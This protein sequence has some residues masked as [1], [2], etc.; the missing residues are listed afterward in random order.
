MEKQQQKTE[1]GEVEWDIS[2]EA[3]KS[4]VVAA[5]HNLLDRLESA[6]PKGNGRF[7][8]NSIPPH[9]LFT[10]WG[11]PKNT[12]L[13][14]TLRWC[15][16]EA[17]TMQILHE[18]PAFPDKKWHIVDRQ[19]YDGYQGRGVF[20]ALLAACEHIVQEFADR[21]K[22]EQ[23]IEVG[24][25]QPKVFSAFEHMGYVV[26][27][28]KESEENAEI[29]RDPESYNT[30]VVQHAFVHVQGSEK[31]RKMAERTSDDPYCFHRATLIEKPSPTQEDAVRVTLAKTFVPS[32]A[33]IERAVEETGNSARSVMNGEGQ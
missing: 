26:V 27:Q 17:G 30:I 4:G 18:A 11:N 28:D 13:E 22:E 24:V 8:D 25:G 14:L 29:L 23:R 3:L 1:G 20:A 16:R 33:P 19:T 5:T 2:R 10:V 12:N 15:G 32:K 31:E 7:I 6:A 21:T 9:I